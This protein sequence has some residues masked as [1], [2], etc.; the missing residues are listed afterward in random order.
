[1]LKNGSVIVIGVLTIDYMNREI[2]EGIIDTTKEKER[3]RERKP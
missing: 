2:Q 1:M 3:E